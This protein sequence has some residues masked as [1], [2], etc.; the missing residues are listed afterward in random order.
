MKTWRVVI[1]AGLLV[2]GT[3][4]LTFLP[5]PKP[6]CQ[7]AQDWA[8]VQAAQGHLPQTLEELSRYRVVYRRA[9]FR[10]LPAA[11]KRALWLEQMHAF[12][13]SHD[14]NTAQV[15][16]IDDASDFLSTA[17]EGPLDQTRYAALTAQVAALFVSTA[18]RRVFT[19]LGPADTAPVSL[20]ALVVPV[21]R[22]D[23]CE[24]KMDA[25][26]WIDDCGDQS[27][28]GGGSGCEPTSVG[29]GVW[30]VQSCDGHCYYSNNG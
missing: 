11:Q 14:L 26:N 3:A 8:T 15:A 20:V 10:L 6:L 28:C 30:W 29:C 5:G 9:A 18:D 25:D 7:V 12:Q 19:R 27:V 1:V 24:C 2:V 21:L 17:Y 23:S 4:G 22:A 16:L 13:A